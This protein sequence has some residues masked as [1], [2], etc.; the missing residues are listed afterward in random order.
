MPD[1][2]A[3]SKLS[4]SLIAET[5]VSAG[6]ATARIVDT[7]AEEWPSFEVAELEKID[8]HID[9]IRAEAKALLDKA[10][11]LSAVWVELVAAIPEM[12]KK[13]PPGLLDMARDRQS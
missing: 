3:K 2:G 10:N 6:W 11:A 7:I 12:A 8:T 1:D 4:V 5:G 9:E 13:I